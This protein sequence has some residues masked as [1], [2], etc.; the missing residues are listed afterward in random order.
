[1]FEAG[2]SLKEAQDRAGHSTISVTADIYTHI[3]IQSKK[4][5]TSF[6]AEILSDNMKRG[7]N[8]TE[9]SIDIG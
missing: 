7:S 3:D 4:R 2:A 1:L 6:M 8:S 9:H 5:L